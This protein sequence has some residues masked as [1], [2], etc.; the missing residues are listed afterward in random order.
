MQVRWPAP[1]RYEHLI[2]DISQD[3]LGFTIHVVGVYEYICE[4]AKRH[5]LSPDLDCEIPHEM[6]LIH[7]PVAAANIARIYEGDQQ[8]ATDTMDEWIAEE[9][10]RQGGCGCDVVAVG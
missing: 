4:H 9:M 5:M 6:Q 1:H 7:P 3:Q 8:R 2:L 10:R